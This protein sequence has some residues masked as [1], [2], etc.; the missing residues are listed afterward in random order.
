MDR[1]PN[2]TEKI[3]GN[4]GAS[5]QIFYLPGSKARHNSL[6]ETLCLHPARNLLIGVVEICEY[7]AQ[8]HLNKEVLQ[9]VGAVC[10]IQPCTTATRLIG[11]KIEIQLGKNILEC[12]N[13]IKTLKFLDRKR[14]A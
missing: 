5:L 4:V 3:D 13:Q 9:G 14:E 2:P 6:L 8:L 12:Q 11:Y 1:A 10:S 7:L